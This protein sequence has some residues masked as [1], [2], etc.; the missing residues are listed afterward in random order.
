MT[1]AAGHPG[2]AGQ[3]QARDMRWNGQAV[4]VTTPAPAGAWQAVAAADRS[5]TPFQT[6]TWRD[7]VCASGEWL[8]TS[9]CYELPDGRVL[10]LMMARRSGGPALLA[11][12]ASWPAGWGSGGLL[13][14]GGTHPDDVALV[15]ADLARSG[16]LSTTVRPSFTAAPA[17]PDAVPGAFTIPRAVHVAHLGRSFGEFWAGSLTKRSRAKIRTARRHVEEAGI[18]FISG[19]SQDL[20]Q[21]FYQVYLRWIDWRAAQRKVPRSV[22]RWQGRRQE[23]LP[24][25]ATVASKLG[26]DC[27]IWVAWWEGRPVGAAISLYAGDMA[28]GWRAFTDRSVPYRFRLH[29]LLITERIQQACERGCHYL[30][31]GESVGARNLASVKERMGGQ[32]HL[33]AEY[34]F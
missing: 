7:C 6:P 26:E 33:I 32:E 12:E 2:V 19:N 1:T 17:W 4:R 34:C 31:L 11:R 10:V 13:A 3:P 9:R 14:T 15:A 16:A 25:F 28:V 21:A 5:V 20:V 24:K 18:V 29:E 8:D 30:E 27:R 23:P 22:A